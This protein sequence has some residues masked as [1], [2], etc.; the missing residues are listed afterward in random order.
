MATERD[1]RPLT[2]ES[3]WDPHSPE[4]LADPFAMHARLRAECPVAYSDRWDG[5][6]TLTRYADVVAAS[7]DTETFTATKQTVIPASPRKGLPRLPLQKDPPEHGRYRSGLNFFFKEKRVRSM[8]ARLRETAIDLMKTMLSGRMPAEYGTGFAGPFTLW[9]I[10]DMVGLDRGEGELLGELSHA[11]V[12]AVQSADLSSA[13]ELSRRIDGFAID[14]VAGRKAEPRD[15]E[16][17]MVTGLMR[18]Q[19]EDGAYDDTELAGM[20]RLMLI[21]GHVV[22]R[23]FLCSAAWHL[24]NDHALQQRLR[25]EPALMRPLIEELLRCYSPN[26]ALVRRTTREVEIGGRHIP[27][28]CPVALNFL[29][30]NRDEEVFTDPDRFDPERS[31]NRH[32]AFGMGPHI[33]IGMSV[34]RLQARIALETLVSM[35]RSFRMTGEPAWARW[36]EFGVTKL[37]LTLD[38]GKPV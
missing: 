30:A 27:E 12:Q 4:A 38:A 23:N 16:T 20:I 10:C 34:A 3:D 31:P 26:Q 13:G 5:F 35:T 37:D 33:C 19:P 15:P 6:Y 28:D 17:D 7:R 1:L 14:I 32:I 2:L 25:T 24:A 22:P 11:Y 8:E 18:I 21:G 9:T 36:T 29:S